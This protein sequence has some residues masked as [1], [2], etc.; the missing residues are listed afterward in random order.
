MRITAT[1]WNRNAGENAIFDDDIFDIAPISR[2]KLEMMD[3]R[4]IENRTFAIFED[5]SLTIARGPQELRLGGSYN[6]EVEFTEQDIL[7]LFS[8]CF[9][10]KKLSE[11]IRLLADES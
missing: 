5:G 9:G 4:K 11:V 1:G 7:F 10:D 8:E 6:I 2:R 3:R